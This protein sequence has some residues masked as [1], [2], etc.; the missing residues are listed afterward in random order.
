MANG[1][2]FVMVVRCPEPECAKRQPQTNQFSRVQ[3]REML[4][5]GEDIR[6]SGPFCGHTWSLTALEKQNLLKQFE[7]GSL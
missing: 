6:V 2:V 3:I 7:A 4:D 1:D 5:A